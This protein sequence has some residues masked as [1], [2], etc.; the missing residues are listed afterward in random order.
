MVFSWL[1]SLI[2]TKLEWGYFE[3]LGFY[4]HFW[5]DYW[6]SYIFTHWCLASN[7]KIIFFQSNLELVLYTNK[8]WY[9]QKHPKFGILISF[10]IS[11]E[12]PEA[13]AIDNWL[14]PYWFDMFGIFQKHPLH[15]LEKSSKMSRNKYLNGQ[16]FFAQKI[17]IFKNT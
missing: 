5:R 9:F 17:K 14:Y 4:T 12:M 6:K 13:E 15:T 16:T 10:L 7:T 3:I 11:H 1:K 8:N 2:S